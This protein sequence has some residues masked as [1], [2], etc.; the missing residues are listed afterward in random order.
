M[1][2]SV[3]FHI[4][5]SCMTDGLDSQVRSHFELFFWV[6]YWSTLICAVGRTVVSAAEP[7]AVPDALTRIGLWFA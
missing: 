2:R 7:E 6:F 3:S 1:P 5:P 4:W